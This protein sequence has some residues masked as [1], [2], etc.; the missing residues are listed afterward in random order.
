MSVVRALDVWE[1]HIAEFMMLY[2]DTVCLC[3]W[4]APDIGRVTCELGVFRRD[5][6]GFKDR[7]FKLGGNFPVV[8]VAGRM[9]GRGT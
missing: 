9:R 8:G 1:P 5:S 6:S 3:V 7:Q 2:M 4:Q